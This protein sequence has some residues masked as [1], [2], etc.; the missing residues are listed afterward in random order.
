MQAAPK[1]GCL[2]S[3]SQIKSVFLSWVFIFTCAASTQA[4]TITFNVS[5]AGGA[6]YIDGVIHADIELTPGNTYV[7]SGFPSFHPLLLSTTKN[8]RWNQ[9]VSYDENVTTTSSSLTI[10]VTEDTP[11]LFYYCHNHSGMGASISIQSIEE[12][13]PA[14]GLGGLL[15]MGLCLTAVVRQTNRRIN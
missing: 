1:V 3:F 13:I 7:F 5:A 12:N 4:E 9:G 10:V 6:Y 15:L 8:G 2:M 11:N 14:V